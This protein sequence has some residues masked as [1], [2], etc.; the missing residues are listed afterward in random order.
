MDWTGTYSIEEFFAKTMQLKSY[1]DFQRLI[2]SQIAFAKHMSETSDNYIIRAYKEFTRARVYKRGN[3]T[4]ASSDNEACASLY[5]HIYHRATTTFGR[6]LF[7][8]F[9]DNRLYLSF[10]TKDNYNKA[11]HVQTAKEAGFRIGGAA[12][13]PFR[14]QHHLKLSHYLDAA[15]NLV[16][17]ESISRRCAI[18]LSPLNIVLTPKT[19]RRGPNGTYSGFKH[20]AWKNDIEISLFKNDVG[21]TPDIRNILHALLINQIHNEPEGKAAYMA[22][23]KLC[24]LNYSKQMDKNNTWLKG[25]EQYSFTFT[26]KTAAQNAIQRPDRE[27]ITPTT[28]GEHR[29]ARLNLKYNVLNLDDIEY[30]IC[31]SRQSTVNKVKRAREFYDAGS[32]F[33]EIAADLHLSEERIKELITGV[34]KVSKE[35]C[36][37]IIRGI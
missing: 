11:F 14:Q 22:Y 26:K 13:K 33:D 9:I 18:F 15:E 19:S 31:N 32:E 27:I 21:E 24:G 37:K 29:M 8:F 16:T 35:Q 23:C 2:H 17:D 4:F 34:N 20:K 3:S 36:Y 10:Q 12:G 5:E 7:Q 30:V 1:P 28:H 6:D 25:C